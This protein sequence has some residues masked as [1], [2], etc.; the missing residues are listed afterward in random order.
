LFL[1]LIFKLIFKGVSQC[2]PTV[3]I[4]YFGPFNPFHYSPLPLYLPYHFSTAFKT[5]HYI[6]YLH[7]L[8][9]EILLML[10]HS[11]YLCHFSEFYK[12]I[13][14]SNDILHINRKHNLEIHMEPQ[15]TSNNQS[16]SEQKV[17]CWR[18]HNT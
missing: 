8:C 10:C 2:M 5:H 15:K 17:Q 16:N 3:S 9:Y 4:L 1:L 11:P 13:P 14:N 6:P 7:V 18:H 12:V